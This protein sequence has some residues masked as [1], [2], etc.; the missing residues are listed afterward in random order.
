MKDT[1]KNVIIGMAAGLVILGF[2]ILRL[3]LQRG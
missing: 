3:L 1:V 2:T